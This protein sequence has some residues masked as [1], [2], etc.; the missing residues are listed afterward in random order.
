MSAQWRLGVKFLRWL[1]IDSCRLVVSTDA[2]HVTEVWFP[3]MRGVHLILGFINLQ[4]VGPNTY[5]RRATFVSEINRGRP[6]ANVW[7]ETAYGW[8]NPSDPVTRPIAIASGA[9][10]DEAINRRDGETLD[11]TNFLIHSPAWLAWKWRD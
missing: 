11:W 1:L 2:A 8:E 10:R 6:L 9:S 4:R 5:N 7:L 3:P